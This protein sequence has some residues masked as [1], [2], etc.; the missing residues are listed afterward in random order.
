[1]MDL[2]PETLEQEQEQKQKQPVF[3][4]LLAFLFIFF[5]SLA[6]LFILVKFL[7]FGQVKCNAR[8]GRNAKVFEFLKLILRP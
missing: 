2:A 4:F 7:T 1:M 5:F 8:D 6:F 3:S